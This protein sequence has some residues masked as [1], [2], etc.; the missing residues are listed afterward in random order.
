VASSSIFFSFL[1]L[2]QPW[3]IRRLPVSTGVALV[4]IWD[5]GLK[6]AAR[7]WLKIQDAK[8]AKNW[9]SWHHRTNLSGYIFVINARIDNRKK[10]LLNSN[11]SSTSAH[12]LIIW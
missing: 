4:R 5:A 11:T 9:S 1:A 8:I 12:V 7:G 3:Q 2:S 6:R 10:N